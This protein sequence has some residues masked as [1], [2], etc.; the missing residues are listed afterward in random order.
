[1]RAQQG[2]QH[3]LRWLL[4]M[5]VYIWINLA[6]LAL[7]LTLCVVGTGW[8][9]GV[10]TSLVA[11]AIVGFLFVYQLKIE[12]QFDA[13]REAYEQFGLLGITGGRSDRRLYEELM[14][15][16]RTSFDIMGHSLSRMYDD[17]GRDL[18]PLMEARGVKIRLLLIH[19]ES[20]FVIPRQEEDPSPERVDLAAEIRKTAKAYISLNLPN[21]SIRFYR[22]CPTLSYQRID[23]IIFAGP[24]FVGLPSGRQSALV[25]RVGDQLS[26]QYQQHFENVWTN[27]SED[28]TT[29]T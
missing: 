23:N 14:K 8:P 1:M 11:S 28:A 3:R 18:L 17:L 12:R 7:G 15:N 4:R 10:G 9:N 2:L 5:T 16:S 24:Y 21:M 20:Q 26:F 19:P 22:C 6:L 25:L 13:A 29:S 27:F